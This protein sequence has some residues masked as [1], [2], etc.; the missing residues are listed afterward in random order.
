L[1]VAQESVVLDLCGCLCHFAYFGL[2]VLERALP[3]R[4]TRGYNNTLTLYS[5]L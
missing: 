1:R 2:S 3:R 5:V 4:K